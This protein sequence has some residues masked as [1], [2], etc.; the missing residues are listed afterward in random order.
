MQVKT[1][2]F[3]A[4]FNR[5]TR[6]GEPFDIAPVGWIADYP[7]PS[8]FLN[9][10]LSSGILPTLDDPATSASS[11][12]PRDCQGRAAT[13]PTAGSTLISPAPLLRGLL[14]AAC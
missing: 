13:S 2:P 6:K 14:S 10:L 3:G 8:Q 9:V 4:M 7:D 1:F 5:L 11:P 12:L